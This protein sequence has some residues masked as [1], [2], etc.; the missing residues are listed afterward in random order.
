MS[1]L[2]VCVF[3]DRCVCTCWH[4]QEENQQSPWLSIKEIIGVGSNIFD[5][6]LSQGPSPPWLPPSPDYS[7]RKRR[8]RPQTGGHLFTE[9]EDGATF[10]QRQL[11][12]PRIIR[13]DI[14]GQLLSTQAVFTVNKGQSQ[15]RWN[16]DSPKWNGLAPLECRR[17]WIGGFSAAVD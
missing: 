11:L 17:N 10:L 15:R 6:R 4:K 1:D 14:G 16:L 8:R 13:E 9:P 7:Q 12:F 5:P 2:C 3:L